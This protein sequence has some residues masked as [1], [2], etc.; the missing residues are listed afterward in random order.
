MLGVHVATVPRVRPQQRLCRRGTAFWVARGDSPS[1]SAVRPGPPLAAGRLPP[2]LVRAH[3]GRSDKRD[4]R[5]ASDHQNGVRHQALLDDGNHLRTP[6][7]PAGSHSRK[8]SCSRTRT[9]A[10]SSPSVPA[11]RRSWRRTSRTSRNRR[12]SPSPSGQ[13]TRSGSSSTSFTSPR[14]RFRATHRAGDARDAL[15]PDPERPPRPLLACAG[16]R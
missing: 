2:A 8:T 15:S 5:G 12:S 10:T 16:V 11:P 6:P 7:S 1:G 4:L 9:T 14:G 3:P 13:S